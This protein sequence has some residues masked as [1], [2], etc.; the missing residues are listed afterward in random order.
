MSHVSVLVARKVPLKI[1]QSLAK[2]LQIPL[3]TTELAPCHS[4][5]SSRDVNCFNE[6]AISA[7]YK[8]LSSGTL[9]I[10]KKIEFANFAV[11]FQSKL[12][13]YWR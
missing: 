2:I 3:I 4:N 10:L 8:Q 6:F 11:V 13:N 12:I 5:I 1:S 9:Q 7:G